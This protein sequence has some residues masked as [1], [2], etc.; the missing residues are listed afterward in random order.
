[1]GD[2]DVAAFVTQVP[3]EGGAVSLSG[4]IVRPRPPIVYVD[5]EEMGGKV[6]NG[7]ERWING[8]FNR[9]RRIRQRLLRKPMRAWTLVTEAGGLG[10]T[11]EDY[12]ADLLAGHES[13]AE[14]EEKAVGEV[15]LEDTATAQDERLPRL[16]DIV[17]ELACNIC[18]RMKFEFFET[19]LQCD[20]CK[21]LIRNMYSK[22]G[23]TVIQVAERI[24]SEQEFRTKHLAACEKYDADQLSRITPKRP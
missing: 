3:K 21:H 12:M 2:K 1:M 5:M 23:Y 20:A 22:V 10:V 15:V 13:E 11:V 8:E 9:Q 6:Y 14:P 4:A 19:E 16:E 24:Q 17:Y 7:I 18:G